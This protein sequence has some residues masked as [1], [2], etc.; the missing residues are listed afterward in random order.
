VTLPGSHRAAYAR[1]FAPLVLVV[2][3]V[4]WYQFSL[5]YIQGANN[6]LVANDNLSVYV[7][8]QQVSAYLEALRLATYATVAAGT[9]AFAYRL[10]KL[11]RTG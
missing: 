10:V 4:F 2:F 7:T 9:L 5:V 8:V 11:I 3:A 1:L 6:Q